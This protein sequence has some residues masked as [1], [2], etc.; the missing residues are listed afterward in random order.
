MDKRQ[1]ERERIRRYLDRER[2]GL[3]RRE[4]PGILFGALMLLFLVLTLAAVMADRPAVSMLFLAL[5]FFAWAG[6]QLNA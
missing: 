5:A 1:E 2:K 6:R 3:V 4:G